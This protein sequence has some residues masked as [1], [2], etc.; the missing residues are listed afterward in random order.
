MFGSNLTSCNY[1]LFVLFDSTKK[2]L[3][4]ANPVAGRNPEAGRLIDAGGL[5]I[6][7]AGYGLR[8]VFLSIARS[9][10]KA[11]LSFFR[12]LIAAR[13]LKEIVFRL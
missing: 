2:G 11:A 9:Y 10:I 6:F 5:Y 4:D 7:T 12:T 13:R 3:G 8:S 1:W